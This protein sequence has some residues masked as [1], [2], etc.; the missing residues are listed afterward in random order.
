MH[1]YKILHTNSE[2]LWASALGPKFIFICS[3]T[4]AVG[5]CILPSLPP[6][7]FFFFLHSLGCNLREGDV[8]NWYKSRTSPVKKK[9]MIIQMYQDDTGAAI[10]TK[11]TFFFSGFFQLLKSSKIYAMGWV[12]PQLRHS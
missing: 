1:I 10:L 2:G 4:D 9:Q 12:R 3:F 6:D 7:F 5:D 11:I 8:G